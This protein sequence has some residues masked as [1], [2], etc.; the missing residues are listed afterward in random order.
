[1]RYA[2]RPP[3]RISRHWYCRSNGRQPARRH[4]RTEAGVTLKAR[5][6]SA[7]VPYRLKMALS[8]A[9]IPAVYRGQP[10]TGRARQA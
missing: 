5:A 4:F 10:L 2:L 6:T 8:S 9:F 7:C 1:M 3:C